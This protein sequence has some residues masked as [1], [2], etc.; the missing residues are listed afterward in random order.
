[1]LAGKFVERVA[2]DVVIARLMRGTASSMRLSKVRISWM[3][4]LSSISF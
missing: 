2:P 4:S 1:M 3:M